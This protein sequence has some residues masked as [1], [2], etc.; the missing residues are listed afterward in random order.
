M[1]AKGARRLWN[2]EKLGQTCRPSASVASSLMALEQCERNPIPLGAAAC[3]VGMQMVSTVV[4]REQL[5]R[6]TRTIQTADE[7]QTEG[8]VYIRSF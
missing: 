4:I 7:K 6:V 3:I 5:R 2:L 1:L 8:H